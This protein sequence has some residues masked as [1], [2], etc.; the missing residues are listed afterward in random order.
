MKR[1]V[2]RYVYY[3][4]LYKITHGY[5]NRAVVI[6]RKPK[7]NRVDD[8]VERYILAR[9]RNYC[10]PGKSAMHSTFIVVHLHI[11]INN[12]GTLSVV[13]EK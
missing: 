13:M 11:V 8:G 12:I 5:S 9:S 10:C 1:P 3:Q 4:S 6:S 7:G 2:C